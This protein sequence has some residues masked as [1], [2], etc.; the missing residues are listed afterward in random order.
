[1]FVCVR[2]LCFVSLL[3]CV[4]P[5]DQCAFELT[6]SY[7]ADGTEQNIPNNM[8]CVCESSDKSG[9]GHG[10]SWYVL[11]GFPQSLQINAAVLL[12]IIL[13]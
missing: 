7:R 13:Y 9:P 10:L 6:H 3:F 8:P 1:V 2:E 11:R 4:V 12:Y 5:T